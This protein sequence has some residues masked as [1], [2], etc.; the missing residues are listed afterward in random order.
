[1]GPM[2]SPIHRTKETPNRAM[3]H[4][5]VNRRLDYSKEQ[6]R[7]SV[8][9]S[10]QNGQ[11][12]K[13]KN[14]RQNPKVGKGKKRAY[15]L[16]MDDDEEDEDPGDVNGVDTTNGND[17]VYDE[18][19]QINNGDDSL[20]MLQDDEDQDLV[21][22]QQSEPNDGNDESELLQDPGHRPSQN[23]SGKLRVNGAVPVEPEFLPSPDPATKKP[24]RPRRTA[25][26]DF[27][28]SQISVAEAKS[29]GGR[30]TKKAK[31]NVQHESE[32]EEDKKSPIPTTQ[33]AVPPA[34]AGSSAVNKRKGP[35]ATPAK[36]HPNARI[37]AAKKVVN[38]TPSVEPEPKR[39]GSARPKPRSLFVLRSETPADDAGALTTRSGRTSVK[40]MAFWR[41]ERIVYGDGNLSGSSLTLPGIKE[42]IRTDEIV[43]P[44]PK[45]APVRRRP[46]RK[47]E[48][49]DLDEEDEEQ[50]PWETNPGTM[51]AEVMRWDPDIGEAI[52][53]DMEETG[54]SFLSAFLQISLLT[55]T[56]KQILHL[57]QQPSK[58]DK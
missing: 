58:C 1:M 52:D 5:L 53:E 15:N 25:S 35:K 42:V 18:S 33:H 43:E 2:S 51:R 47:R 45:R 8:S 36:R 54:Q 37:I 41:N 12:S 20:L 10:L 16:S 13:L 56:A 19:A 7:P 11:L 22:E 50:E 39:V 29:R 6:L 28:A 49:E 57:L 44:K 40:P 30:P 23:P 3:S 34:K 21:E 38:K 26:V 31:T 55:V 46:A 32:A 24:G 14:G 17:L 9:S 27:D 4:P 48:L